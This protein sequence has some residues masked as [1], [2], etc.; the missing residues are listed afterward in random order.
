MFPSST[1][2]YG[3]FSNCKL[4]CLRNSFRGEVNP[5]LKQARLEG[6]LWD[7]KGKS[8]LLH[9]SI[10]LGASGNQNT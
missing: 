4:T 10:F 8:I 5:V 1:Q 6:G 9:I 7:N 2:L 3:S